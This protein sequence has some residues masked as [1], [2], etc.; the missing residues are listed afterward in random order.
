MT[1]AP[2]ERPGVWPSTLEV[3]DVKDHTADQLTLCFSLPPA[4][5][6]PA[7]ARLACIECGTVEGMAERKERYPRGA[8]SVRCTPCYN[9][10][11]VARRRARQ[12]IKPIRKRPSPTR[13]SCLPC[14][15]DFIGF[16]TSIRCPR[17]QH[18]RDAERRGVDFARRRKVIR[19]GDRAITWR[20]VGER[21]G[22]VCHLC[23]LPVKRKADSPHDP[24]SAT[25]DHILPIAAG[26]Q[27]EWSNVALAHWLCN[28]SRGARDHVQLRPVG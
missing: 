18:E 5:R 3:L 11:A 10:Y 17:C 27:H 22:W 12:P 19:N 14:G 21:D 25:V 1:P 24:K 6:R 23:H 26:G 8:C 7:G 15:I 13:R 2:L 4:R 28:V 9:A 20:S 16:S